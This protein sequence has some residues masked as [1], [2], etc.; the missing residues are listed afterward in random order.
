MPVNIGFAPSRHPGESS[1]LGKSYLP[2]G[3]REAGAL[4]LTFC[5]ASENGFLPRHSGF[6]W[7]PCRLHW[8]APSTTT[9]LD[10]SLRWNDGGAI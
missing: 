3:S 9:T 4:T 7:N 6:R 2:V 5:Y 8:P 1:Y 10:S